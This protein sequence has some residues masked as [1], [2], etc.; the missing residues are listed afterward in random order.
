M[1]E[2][3]KDKLAVVA[4]EKPQ[5]VKDWIESNRE[6]LELALPDAIGVDRMISVAITVLEGSKSLQACTR[7]SLLAGLV[8]SAQLGL[9][10]NTPL[11]YA[12]LIPYRNGDKKEAQFQIGY[13]GLVELANRTGKYQQIY[14]VCVHERDFFKVEYGLNRNLIHRPPEE[15][16]RG[17][18]IGYYAV[19]KLTNGGFNFVYKT[20]AEIEAHAKDKS[21][22]YR[23]GAS[24]PWKTDFDA[25]A[26]KTVLKMVLKT[27]PKTPEL[28]NAMQSD[29]TIKNEFGKDMAKVPDETEEFEILDDEEGEEKE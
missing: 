25:M 23:K 17:P 10:V 8:T 2:N 19:Y 16:F 3:V 14:A 26:K 1:A 15:G 4:K 24:T 27:G 9:E 13:Q 28:V 22:P 20:K 12:Y 11:G 7:S 29:N 5:T 18:V 6:K 21:I